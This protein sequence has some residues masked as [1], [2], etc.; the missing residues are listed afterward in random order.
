M[1]N[2]DKLLQKSDLNLQRACHATVRFENWVLVCGGQTSNNSITSKCEAFN[3]Q[4]EEWEVF[5]DMIFGKII[6]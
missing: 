2:K 1:F 3:L 5:E 6:K 4:T